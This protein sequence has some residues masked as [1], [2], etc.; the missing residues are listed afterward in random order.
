MV[1]IRASVDGISDA[2]ARPIARRAPISSAGVRAKAAPREA[3]ENTVTPADGYDG[4]RPRLYPGGMPVQVIVLNGGSSTGK[5][6]LSRRL[7][8]VLP[9]PWLATGVDRL[10][11][12]MPAS[13]RATGA[14]VEFAPDGAV[15]LGPEF[16]RLQAAWMAGVAATV[17]A[18][19][20]VIL[21]EVFLG[22][23]ASQRRWRDVLGDLVVLWVAVRCDSAVVAARVA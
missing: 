5:S 15:H 14:G 12:S 23:G 18:G 13:L 21:D 6:E 10:I 3:A 22:G 2:P 7:Q 9:D 11:E 17:R 8:A 1:R 19:A 4:P 20:P 16:D